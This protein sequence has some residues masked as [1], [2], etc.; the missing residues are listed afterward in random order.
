MNQT[1]LRLV[2]LDVRGERVGRPL[3]PPACRGACQRGGRQLD[4]SS[5]T[6]VALARCSTVAARTPL[7]P[8]PFPPSRTRSKHPPIERQACVKGR[9]WLSAAGSR[10]SAPKII[11]CGQEN[12]TVQTSVLL[13]L[14][15]RAQQV[16]AP[17]LVVGEHNKLIDINE[18]LR[19]VA[20]PA[21]GSLW[22]QWRLQRQGRGGAARAWGASAPKPTSRPLPPP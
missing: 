18:R 4:G 3:L 11:I 13:V 8:A 1:R 15:Q 17:R 10:H 14:A 16:G 2:A 12:K 7:S 21:V 19:R 6:A 5:A 22:W 20:T 9:G